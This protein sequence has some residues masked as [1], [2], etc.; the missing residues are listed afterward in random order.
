LALL[1]A[2]ERD[3]FDPLLGNLMLVGERIGPIARW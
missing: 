3:A 1:L 2:Q